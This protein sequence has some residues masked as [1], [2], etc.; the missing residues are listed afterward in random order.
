MKWNYAELS[1]LAKKAGGPE[2]LLQKIIDASRKQGQKDMIPALL[3]M[4][5]AGSLLT[6]TINKLVKYFKESDENDLEQAK[7]EIIEGIKEYDMA[8]K[9]NDIP[10]DEKECK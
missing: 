1:K 3:L 8:Q 4:F 2:L 10:D 6:V 9:E 5:G 7:K